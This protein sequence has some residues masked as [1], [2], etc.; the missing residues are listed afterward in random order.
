MKLEEVQFK[1][2]AEIQSL[3]PTLAEEFCKQAIRDIYNEYDWSFL[4]K[5]DLL[6]VPAMINSGTVSVEEFS[7]DVQTS[8]ELRA[9]LDAITV[10]NVKLE[11]RQFRTFGGQYA[12]NNFIYTI[13]EYDSIT[14]IFKIDPYYQDQTDTSAR[15]QIFKNLYT[16]SE[17]DIDFAYFEYILAPFDQRKLGLELTIGELN[18]RDPSRT[19]MGDPRYIVNY[20]EDSSGN[21]LFEL[22]PIPVNKRIYKIRYKRDGRNIE[23]DANIPSALSYDLVIAKAKIKAYEWLSTN[24]DKVGDKR[25]PNVFMNLIAMLSNPNMENSYP[26]K[27]R[28]AISRDENL[29]S[30][31]VIDMGSNFDYYSEVVVETILLDF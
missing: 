3:P 15:F 2:L 24:G 16:T 11:G 27:L 18:R 5:R 13:K 4:Y 12:G 31:S 26:K 30:Q 1:L 14:G 22:Y 23:I 29:H 21:Q 25:S 19:S 17:I 7:E 28:E 6:R 9:I 10:N 8:T 20:D